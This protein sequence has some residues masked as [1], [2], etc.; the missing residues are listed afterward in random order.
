MLT[1][2]ASVQES[3][4]SRERWFAAP[5]RELLGRYGC[6]VASF[7]CYVWLDY[8]FSYD[9]PF[10]SVV[11][12]CPEGGE[13]AISDQRF[14]RAERNFWV[15]EGVGSVDVNFSCADGGLAPALQPIQQ[16]LC[17]L[18]FL[19]PFGTDFGFGATFDRRS[20]FIQLVKDSRHRRPHFSSSLRLPRVP[21]AA[22]G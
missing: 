8:G 21:L 10:V 18:D 14:G 5:S 20:P 22:W 19:R 1:N 6:Y 15:A 9:L 17:V 2:G 13:P 16:F 11:S 7:N 4:R 12:A 3:V